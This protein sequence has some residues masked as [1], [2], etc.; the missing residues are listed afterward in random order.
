[1]LPKLVFLWRRHFVFNQSSDLKKKKSAEQ[2]FHFGLAVEVKLG[3]WNVEQKEE[4][5]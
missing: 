2:K 4:V 1:M 3:A 5:T